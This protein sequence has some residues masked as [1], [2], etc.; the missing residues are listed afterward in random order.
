MLWFA[1]E[2]P[3]GKQRVIVR[4]VLDCDRADIVRSDIP[5]EWACTYY[6]QLEDSDQDLELC[7]FF[8]RPYLWT[9]I[10]QCRERVLCWVDIGGYMRTAQTKT[11]QIILATSVSIALSLLLT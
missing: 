5:V 8:R 9:R 3:A 11:E 6:R 1:R 7:L 2:G 4:P 10:D